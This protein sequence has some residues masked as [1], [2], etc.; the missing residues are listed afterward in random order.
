LSEDKIILSGMVF[1][2]YHGADPS[3]QTLGQRFE[4][5]LEAEY[6]LRAAGE[7]DALRFTVNYSQLFKAVKRV[8]EGPSVKL[9]EALAERIASEVLERTP[10]HAVTVRVK[11]PEV[12]IKASIMEYAAVQVYRRREGAG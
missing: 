5:D 8:I 7:A 10:V 12:P 9:L 6:D 2:G 4:V 3:E 11:K 1:Y